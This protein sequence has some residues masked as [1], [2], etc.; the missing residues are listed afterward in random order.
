MEARTTSSCAETFLDLEEP[1]MAL[2]VIQQCGQGSLAEKMDF[3]K[4]KSF[5]YKLHSF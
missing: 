2:A 4:V 1:K 3:N 5:G